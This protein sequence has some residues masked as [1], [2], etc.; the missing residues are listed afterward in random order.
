MPSAAVELPAASVE[1]Y[2]ATALEECLREDVLLFAASAAKNLRSCAESRE[3]SCPALSPVG[4]SGSLVQQRYANLE[5]NH[6]PVKRDKTGG[7]IRHE[8]LNDLYGEASCPEY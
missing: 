3:Q 7:S 6:V 1:E 8:H 2:A 5:K 4:R